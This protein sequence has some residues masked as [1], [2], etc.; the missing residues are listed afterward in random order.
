MLTEAYGN[1]IEHLDL[2]AAAAAASSSDRSKLKKGQKDD[3]ARAK[4]GILEEFEKARGDY[5]ETMQRARLS[6]KAKLLEKM[7]K[8]KGGGG[9]GGAGKED[10]EDSKEGGGGGGSSEVIRVAKSRALFEQVIDSFLDDPIEIRTPAA[11]LAHPPASPSRTI[12]SIPT[13]SEYEPSST[14]DKAESKSGEGERAGPPVR[15][16][17]GRGLSSLSPLK[18]LPPLT[19]LRDSAS[20]LP[21]GNLLPLPSL[22]GHGKSDDGSSAQKD[23]IKALHE[24]KE[25]VLVSNSIYDMNAILGYFA[26][27]F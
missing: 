17:G 3:L 15:G 21:Q 16:L 5:N 14:L 8:G 10:F 11:L 26:P 24:E 7:R 9:K 6:S 2:D 1:Q 27:V 4:T 20:A 12:P 23:I 22:L 25:K 18:K 19:S 13:P